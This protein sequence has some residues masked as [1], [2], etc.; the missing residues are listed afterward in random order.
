MRNFKRLLIALGN[1]AWFGSVAAVL[2]IVQ[3]SSNS[4][5]AEEAKA[6]HR[7]PDRPMKRLNFLNSARWVSLRGKPD[8]FILDIR[9]RE[10]YAKGHILGSKNIPLY[11]LEMR[12]L[13][14]IPRDTS[15]IVYCGYDEKCEEKYRMARQPTPCTD[16][17]TLLLDRFGFD[18]VTILAVGQNELIATG[19]IFSSHSYRLMH[20]RINS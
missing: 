2:A 13:R 17:A 19:T 16:V 7:W 5:L 18:K 15:I 1:L 8:L 6:S 12:A 4:Q 14:E 9:T 10:D 3:I 11:E 20:E